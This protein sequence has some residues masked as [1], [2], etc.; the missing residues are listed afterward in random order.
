MP[1]DESILVFL[2]E[3]GA[4]LHALLVRLTLRTDVADDLMQDLFCKLSHDAR[5]LAARNPTAYAVRMATNL[6]FDHRRAQARLRAGNLLL[7]KV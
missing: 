5:W 3:Q 7:S 2:E 4:R 1:G 6:A